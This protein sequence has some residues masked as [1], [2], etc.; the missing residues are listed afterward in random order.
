MKSK[1]KEKA[2]VSSILLLF[3]GCTFFILENVFYQYIDK[4]GVLHESF[5]MPLSFLCIFLSVIVF[6]AVVISSLLQNFHKKTRKGGR[7]F[8][9]I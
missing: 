6:L 7:S 9:I 8:R 4:D 3:S 2:I 1:Y 5:F